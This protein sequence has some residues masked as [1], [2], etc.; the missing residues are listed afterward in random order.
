MGGNKIVNCIASIVLCFLSTLTLFSQEK[1]Q[2]YF[3][4]SLFTNISGTYIFDKQNIYHRYNEYTLNM[5]AGIQILKPIFIGFEALSIF[6]NGTSV[7]SNNYFIKGGFI[8]YEVLHKKQGVLFFNTSLLNGDYCTCGNQDPY[9]YDNLYYLGLEI[10]G[11][12]FFA[13]SSFYI[14]T[15]LSINK[16]LNNVPLKYNYNIYK[17]GIGYSFGKKNKKKIIT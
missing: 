2:N 10:G 3:G 7:I 4:K 13:Q 9:R 17:I 14:N 12:V 1:H 5:Q 11:N 8:R 15:S 6:T 16:I